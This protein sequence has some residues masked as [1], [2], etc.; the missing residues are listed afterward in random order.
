MEFPRP[1][2]VCCGFLIAR[3]ASLPARVG[4]N[5]MAFSLRMIFSK[6]R[7]TLFRIML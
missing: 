7:F 1:V 5:E 2:V 3:Q 6:N 4:L